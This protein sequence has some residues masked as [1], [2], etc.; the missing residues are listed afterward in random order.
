MSKSNHTIFVGIDTYEYMDAVLSGD[1]ERIA[2]AEEK[3]EIR[4]K[5]QAIHDKIIRKKQYRDI[6]KEYGFRVLWLFKWLD[7]RLDRSYNNGVRGR[8]RWKI[9]DMAPFYKEDYDSTMHFT[10]EEGKFKLSVIGYD[11][12]CGWDRFEDNHWEGEY[13][14]GIYRILKSMIDE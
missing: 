2:K 10:F 5:E 6:R 13:S 4:R 12:Y 7:K 3:A 1:K 9:K 8:V 11:T 14:S